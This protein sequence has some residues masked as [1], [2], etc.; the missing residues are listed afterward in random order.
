MYTRD[1][2]H[3][4]MVTNYINISTRLVSVC[5]RDRLSCGV[6]LKAVWLFKLLALLGIIMNVLEYRE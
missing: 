1:T 3:D 2:H 6:V 4:G 5:I